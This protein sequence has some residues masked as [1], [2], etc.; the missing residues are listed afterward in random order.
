MF[1]PLGLGGDENDQLIL[2]TT[3][4]SDRW[5]G[6]LGEVLGKAL[7]SGG[8]RSSFRLGGSCCSHWDVAI[9]VMKH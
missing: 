9:A 8:D 6:F 2:G 7:G 1:L 5:F 4:F 3:K